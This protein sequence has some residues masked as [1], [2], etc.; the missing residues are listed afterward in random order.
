MWKLFEEHRNHGLNSL[1]FYLL[2]HIVF[3]IERFGS[4]LSSSASPHEHYTLGIRQAFEATLK[5]I[6]TKIEDIVCLFGSE[7]K[8]RKNNVV[9]SA[10][11]TSRTAN[12]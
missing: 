5:S 7:L 8:K 12:I 11:R 3:H 10:L 9:V 2:E 4:M 1:K 6:I